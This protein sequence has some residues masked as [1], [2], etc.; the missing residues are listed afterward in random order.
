M[1]GKVALEKMPLERLQEGIIPPELLQLEEWIMLIIHHQ[2]FTSS[3][4]THAQRGLLYCWVMIMSLSVF[5]LLRF[6]PLRAT[7]QQK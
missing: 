5:H 7:R 3:P 1:Q 6:L 2:V 4:S